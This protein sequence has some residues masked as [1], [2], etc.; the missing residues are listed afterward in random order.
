MS[1]SSDLFNRPRFFCDIH[2][3]PWI[4]GKGNQRDYVSAV[5]SWESFHNK[6]PRTKNCKIPEELCGIMLRSH[7]YGCA[8]DLC[9]DIPFAVIESE[10]GV[11]KIC[12]ELHKSDALSVVSNICHDFL[13]ILSSERGQTKNDRNYEVRFAAAMAQFNSIANSAISEFLTAFMLLDNSSIESNQR[14]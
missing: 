12:K 14:I 9:K 2:T 7:L 13:S 4:A 6:L 8:K 11:E 10:D 5:K 1:N 3:A